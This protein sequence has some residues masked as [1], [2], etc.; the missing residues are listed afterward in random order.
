VFFGFSTF[1]QHSS[2]EGKT[3][4]SVDVYGVRLHNK[5]MIV[6][7]YVYVCVSAGSSSLT[8]DYYLNSCFS[9]LAS[10]KNRKSEV[11]DDTRSSLAMVLEET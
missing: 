9:L 4:E 1:T 5:I 6:N 2:Y 8:R 10:P 3:S 11:L 7:V